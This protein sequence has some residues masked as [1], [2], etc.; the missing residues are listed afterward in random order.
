[1]VPVSFTLALLLPLYYSWVVWDRWWVSP[2]FI[3]MLVMAPFK[4]VPWGWAYFCWVWPG[5]I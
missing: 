4:F 2:V 1:M 5:L 3:G